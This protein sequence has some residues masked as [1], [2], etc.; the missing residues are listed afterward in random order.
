MLNIEDIQNILVFM[1]R[2][3]LKG[4]EA[5]VFASLV[6]KLQQYHDALKRASE[7]VPEVNPT[8]DTVPTTSNGDNP[9]SAE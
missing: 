9:E 2:S 5:M 4:E 3:D 8:N 1:R 7:P 6:V